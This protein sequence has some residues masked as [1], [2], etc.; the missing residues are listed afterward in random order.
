[1]LIDLQTDLKSLRFGNDRPG[2]GD[3]GQP[4]IQTPIPDQV[5][6]VSA[7]GD[8]YN[9]STV[10]PTIPIQGL[11]D[12]Q[13]IARFLKSSAGQM[14]IERQQYLQL[15]NPDI[16]SGKEVAIGGPVGLG[17]LGATRIYNGSNTLAQVS[18]QGSGYHYDRHGYT[19][20]NSYRSTYD[21]V[22]TPTEGNDNPQR[23][24]TLYNTKIANL[25]TGTT[26]QDANELNIS[27]NPTL[28]I[29][30]D[31]GPN[32]I[33]GIGSTVIPRFSNTDLLYGPAGTGIGAPIFDV[34]K[35][36]SGNLFRNYS[37]IAKIAAASENGKGG[38]YYDIQTSGSNQ[39]TDKLPTETNSTTLPEGSTVGTLNRVNAS[40]TYNYAQ[41]T[42]AYNGSTV[43]GKN[44]DHAIL[45]DFR[46]VFK[47]NI[48]FTQG[49]SNNATTS[50]NI[51]TRSGIG[52]P[53]SR[54][55]NQRVDYTTPYPDGQD[56]INKLDVNETSTVKDLITFRFDTVELESDQRT[57]GAEGTTAL[58]FRAFLTGLTDNHAA[59][60]SSVKYVGRGDKFYTY[61]GFT[62]TLSFNFKIA[63]QS[64]QEMEPLYRKLNY[65]ISQM[66]PD[67]QGFI[68][69]GG[70]TL[71][72]GFM[73]SPLVKLTIG[74]YIAAQP[75]FITSMNITVPDDSPWDINLE[76]YD[77]MYQLPH[78]L[79][80]ACQF[81][82][83]HD[84]LPRRSWIPFGKGTGK[85]QKDYANITPLITP[86]KGGNGN[87]WNIGKN[88]QTANNADIVN[89]DSLPFQPRPQRQVD[90]QITP[91][92][93]KVPSFS[94][95]PTTFPQY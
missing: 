70:G 39:L 14:F 25:Q 71:G 17:F 10:G 1:M 63:A 30:Y 66:Y 37:D 29:Q 49:Y 27:S 32:S 47:K 79:D 90:N 59:E 91:M 23:L 26:A 73:R 62:R 40:Y 72:N 84:F 76:E 60:Y 78:V 74:D 50:Y 33:G 94:P 44:T 6:P 77:D 46:S 31:G 5:P 12:T 81:T 87:N 24:V 67:Y 18:V 15:A 36:A 20:V 54:P 95:P 8:L 52:S 64:R 55:M 83:I 65:L 58:I 51:A 68:M 21:Y 42:A 3:S 61:D 57:I 4:F 53:G 43:R 11:A 34:T 89:P 88:S 38:Y 93:V 19:P 69:S 2:G 86:N 56:V 9:I 28:L 45:E 92:T 48:A 82:P 16:Q 7:V 13:R 80:V 85:E 41:I 35:T 22:V 75:G